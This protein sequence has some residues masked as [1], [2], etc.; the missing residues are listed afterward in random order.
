MSPPPFLFL[1]LF[2]FLFHFCK[3]LKQTKK[4]NENYDWSLIKAQTQSQEPNVTFVC[5]LLYAAFVD[6]DCS[7][8][9]GLFAFDI[10]SLLLLQ[11]FQ[12]FF[13]RWTVTRVDFIFTAKKSYRFYV[14]EGKGWSPIIVTA[15]SHHFTL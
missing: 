13:Q 4:K 9:I 12:T 3:E 10:L 11:M 14:V 5:H 6:T 15:H 1:F 8:F 7:L 2:L